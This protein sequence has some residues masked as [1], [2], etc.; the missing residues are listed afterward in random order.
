VEQGRLPLDLETRLA[1][2]PLNRP[3]TG[4]ETRWRKGEI[5]ARGEKTGEKHVDRDL[6]AIF[7]A[8]FPNSR[9]KRSAGAS[10]LIPIGGEAE[11]FATR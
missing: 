9:R 4:A 7:P 1:F 6:I 2:G 10:D 8:Y 3:S 11:R 5:D